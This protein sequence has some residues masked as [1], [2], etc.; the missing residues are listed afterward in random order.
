MD[1]IKFKEFLKK[2]RKSDDAIETCVNV[3][4]E[5]ESFLLSENVSLDT[6]S[7]KELTQLINGNLDSKRVS[8]LRKKL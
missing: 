2:K 5:F 7:P 6:M 3:V 4:N 8:K 1:E